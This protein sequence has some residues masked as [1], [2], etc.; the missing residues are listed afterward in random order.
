[1]SRIAASALAVIAALITMPVLAQEARPETTARPEAES[2]PGVTAGRLHR[3]DGGWR[4]SQIVGATVYN[5]ADQRI[6][7]VDDLIIGQGGKIETVVLSVGGFLGMG[8]KLVKVSYDKLRF[9]ERKPSDAPAKQSEGTELAPPPA[10]TGASTTEPGSTLR[11]VPA[12]AQSPRAARP[13]NV[14]ITRIVLPGASKE[15]LTALPKFDYG[16]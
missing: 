5:D 8:S 14:T 15:S 10:G 1:M 6:G 2:L 3:A 7:T 16:T 11:D 12:S 13:P 9:E 4:S